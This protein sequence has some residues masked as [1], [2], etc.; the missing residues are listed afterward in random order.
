MKEKLTKI[1]PTIK[2]GDPLN[3]GN[4]MGPLHSKAGMKVY[5]EGIEEIKK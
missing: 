5:L 4:L 3:P 1:Y 2:I